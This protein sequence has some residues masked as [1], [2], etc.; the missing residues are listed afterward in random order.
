ML[1]IAR[2]CSINDKYYDNGAYHLHTLRPHTSAE[3]IS[4]T[5]LSSRNWSRT[6][7]CGG[8][9]VG[10]SATYFSPPTPAASLFANGDG[11]LS[12]HPSQ[13]VDDRNKPYRKPDNAPSKRRN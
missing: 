2:V 11:P 8:P 12:P 6:S 3:G 4:D 5:C 9:W 7:Y 1:G 10:E 13:H